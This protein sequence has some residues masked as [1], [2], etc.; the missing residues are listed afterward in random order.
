MTFRHIKK[1]IYQWTIK[2]F[3][4]LIFILSAFLFIERKVTYWKNYPPVSTDG[5][6]LIAE[7]WDITIKKLGRIKSIR[8]VDLLEFY[9]KA[10][11]Y[12]LH[13]KHK[14]YLD[15]KT[16]IEALKEHDRL[17][18]YLY[19]QEKKRQDV[20]DSKAKQ[21]ISNASIVI[22]I[23]GLCLTIL[24]SFYKDRIEISK[25]DF[26]FLILALC[27]LFLSLALALYVLNFRKYCRPFPE[28]IFESKSVDEERFLRTK[29]I[30]FHGPII[31]NTSANSK[32]SNWL[33]CSNYAFLFALIMIFGIVTKNLYNLSDKNIIRNTPVEK[34]VLYNRI[35][36]KKIDSTLNILRK[37]TLKVKIIK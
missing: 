18:S 25:Y 21:N 33:I 15:K 37:D 32:K 4:S 11:S 5:Y 6:P 30:S 2:K 13:F 12:Y 26:Y 23:I 14:S 24:A 10:F 9:Y 1:R 27:F 20:C 7:V 22:T 29:I 19:D 17:I 3:N 34:Q 16:R 31:L 8:Y 36:S 35:D 28:F